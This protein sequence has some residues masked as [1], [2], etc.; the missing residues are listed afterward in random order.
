MAQESFWYWL[1]LIVFPLLG[2][3]HF[4]SN[5][6]ASVISGYTFYV[7]AALLQGLPFF[8]VAILLAFFPNT[9]IILFFLAYIPSQIGKTWASLQER[10]AKQSDPTKWE[11]W[12]IKRE[13][14][15]RYFF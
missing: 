8:V 15:M 12:Q 10:N 2:L 3:W 9:G 4:V 1:T 13:K 7:T 5:I 11:T 14:L 6:R